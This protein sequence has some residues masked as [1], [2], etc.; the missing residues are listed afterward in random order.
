MQCYLVVT[1]DSNLL[2]IPKQYEAN[3]VRLSDYACIVGSDDDSTQDIATAF[4]INQDA[5]IN[6]RGIVAELH[7]YTGWESEIVANKII[8]LSHK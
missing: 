5:S 8:E 4:D 2:D 6:K 7:V 3:A 1:T